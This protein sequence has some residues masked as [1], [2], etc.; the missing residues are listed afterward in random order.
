M[1]IKANKNHL[2]SLLY[3]EEMC[4]KNDCFK[5][6]RANFLYHIKK[7]NILIYLKDEKVVSY[8]L[9]ITYKN[10][11]RIYSLA[12]DKNYQ[13]MSLATKLCENII[14]NSNKKIYLEV[15]KSNEKAI[16]LYEKLGFKYQKILKNY[17]FDEDG[18]K[19]LREFEIG[20]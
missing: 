5:L 11:I 17:Y 2:D 12:V 1:I 19:M 20:N 4:F 16:R 3:L 9:S 10:S 18:I 15:R 8:I 14:N 6:S 13:N 7:E